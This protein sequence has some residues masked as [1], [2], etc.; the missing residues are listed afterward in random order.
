MIVAPIVEAHHD[1]LTGSLVGAL[2]S[3]P[4][5][6]GAVQTP[7]GA[8][9]WAGYLASLVI[10]LAPLVVKAI[11]SAKGKKLDPA[12]ETVIDD[13]AKLAGAAVDHAKTVTQNPETD[14]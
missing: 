2:T 4:L 3:L 8:P 11:L 14:R 5:A 7:E 10:A 9:W 12:E 13:A 1:A 6:V